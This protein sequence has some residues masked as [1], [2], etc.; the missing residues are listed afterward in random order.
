MS[1]QPR[2]IGHRSVLYIMIYMYLEWQLTNHPFLSSLFILIQC[3][4][5]RDVF[6][7]KCFSK[8]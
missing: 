1:S 3:V 2:K 5:C 8:V 4:V 6:H 7:T